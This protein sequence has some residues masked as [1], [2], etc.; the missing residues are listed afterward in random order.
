MKGERE[1]CLAA[2]CDAYLSKPID[3]KTL[4]REAAKHMAD[5]CVPCPA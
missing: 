4:I 1:K 2:G 5:K 3:K